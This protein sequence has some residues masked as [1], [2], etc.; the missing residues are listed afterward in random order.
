MGPI[1]PMTKSQRARIANLDNRISILA[2]KV[3]PLLTSPTQRERY[4]KR[5]QV[6]EVRKAVS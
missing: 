5:L 6:S 3:L 2:A 1:I 4:A